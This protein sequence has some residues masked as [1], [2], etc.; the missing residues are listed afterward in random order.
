MGTLRHDAASASGFGMATEFQAA[1]GGPSTPEAIV[2]GVILAG[3][4]RW[5]AFALDEVVSRSLWP[6]AGRSVIAH[7]LKWLRKAGVENV[8][9]CANSDTQYMYRLLGTG[10]TFRMQLDYYMDISPRGPAGCVRDAMLGSVARA[11]VVVEGAILPQIDLDDLLRKHAESNAALTM[12]VSRDPVADQ[13][14]MEMLRPAGIYVFA[15]R[16]SA[17]IPERGYQDIKETLVPKLFAR[18]ENI[19]SYVVDHD[20]VLRIID[21]A[22]YHS[23]NNWVIERMARWGLC[24]ADYTRHKLALVHKTAKVSSGAR[25]L[26]PVLIEP[27][28]VVEDQAIIVGPMV[29]GVGSHIGRKVVVSRSV[30]WHDCHVQTQAKLDHC[31][32]THGARIE[33]YAAFDHMVCV[34][35]YLDCSQGR[36]ALS[37]LCGDLAIRQTAGP[38]GDV[39]GSKRRE[40]IR[41]NTRRRQI[42]RDCLV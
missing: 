6:V 10:C 34:G 21:T 22:S 9:I 39:K 14:G 32:L 20:A 40:I 38:A 11:F 31:I 27:S 41:S 8:T 24:P 25:L 13:A 37:P 18:G 4:H 26:G 3:I 16:I 30:L 36:L 29:L 1:G 19:A 35:D 42:V 5:G 7:T 2:Q 23:V 12:V 28:C 15:P 17:D 33:A